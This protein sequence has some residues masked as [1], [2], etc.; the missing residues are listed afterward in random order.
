MKLDVAE[1]CFMGALSCALQHFRRHVHADDAPCRPDH[2]SGDEAVQPCAA[3]DIYDLLA[4]VQL[5]QS[6]RI[7]RTGERL[8]RDFGHAGEPLIGIAENVGEPPSSVEVEAFFG[9]GGHLRI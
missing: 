2:T 9:L 3:A 7:A 5:S 6:E 4:A 1:T 8:Y